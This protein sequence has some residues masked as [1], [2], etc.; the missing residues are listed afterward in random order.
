[1]KLHFRIITYLATQF[2]AITLN[3]FSYLLSELESRD[4]NM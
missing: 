1:M 2:I 4:K 3:L